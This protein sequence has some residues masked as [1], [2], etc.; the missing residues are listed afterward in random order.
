[1]NLHWQNVVANM[2][3]SLALLAATSLSNVAANRKNVKYVMLP[4]G[5]KGAKESKV[6][7]IFMNILLTMF[8]ER[9]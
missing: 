4:T 1:M 5:A 8:A 7:I 6:A 2:F 9:N 3:T